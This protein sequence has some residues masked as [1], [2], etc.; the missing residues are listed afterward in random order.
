MRK[1][2][3]GAIYLQLNK[4]QE[5][6]R[7]YTQALKIYSQCGCDSMDLSNTYHNVGNIYMREKMYQIA[8][9]YFQMSIEERKSKSPEAELPL[10]YSAFKLGVSQKLEQKYQESIQTLLYAL[11]FA[12]RGVGDIVQVYK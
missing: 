11:S 10:F 7:N 5:S 9:K 1:S 8:S 2:N 6:L 3:L 12:E 4:N